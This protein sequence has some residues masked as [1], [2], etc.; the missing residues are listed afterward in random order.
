MYRKLAKIYSLQ[1]EISADEF[2]DMIQPF[3]FKL[4]QLINKVHGM[5]TLEPHA[6]G[7][8]VLAGG[9]SNLPIL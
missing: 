1:D 9:T 6:I 3:R 5:L 4:I 2:N 7:Q 8:V